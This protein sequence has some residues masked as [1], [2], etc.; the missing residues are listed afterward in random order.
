MITIVTAGVIIV[1]LLVGLPLLAWWLGS[2]DFWSRL[3]PRRDDD[4]WGD[5]VRT[6]RLR[7][8]EI[9]EVQRAVTWG[10]ELSDQ[11]LRVAAV[12]WATRARDWRVPPSR[13]A[14]LLLLLVVLWFVGQLVSLV[15]AL[16]QGRWGDA[17]VPALLLAAGVVPLVWFR[18]GTRRAIELNSR[19][20]R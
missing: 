2:R 19:P 17:L 14:R 9:V 15:V 10:R 7:P 4:V 20:A 13:H 1:L 6:H 5:V 11:R 16:V 3:R 8:A 12:D 18:R